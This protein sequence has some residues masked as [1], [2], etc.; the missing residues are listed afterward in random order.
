MIVDVNNINK[1]TKKKNKKTVAPH[2]THLMFIYSS[3]L[4]I[5]LIFYHDYLPFPCNWIASYR[6]CLSSSL[7]YYRTM[8]RKFKGSGKN[9]FG[10]S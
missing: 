3:C 5:H 9:R 7:Q 8:P 2:I 1:Q 4:A 10:V 6:R